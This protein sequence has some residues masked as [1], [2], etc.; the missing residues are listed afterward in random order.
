MS[1]IA[2]LAVATEFAVVIS[3][4][5]KILSTAT[6]MAAHGK[7]EDGKLM[8]ENSMARYKAASDA[9]RAEANPNDP[10]ENSNG[11]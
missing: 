1:V 2:F 8:L 10:E 7:E 9:Y 3:E 6:Q 5:A 4:G 11:G